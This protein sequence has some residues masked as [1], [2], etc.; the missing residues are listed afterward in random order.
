MTAERGRTGSLRDEP[1]NWL[2]NTSCQ[3]PNRKHTNN[4]NGLKFYFYTD[5]CHNSKEKEPF[6]YKVGRIK[7]GLEGETWEEMEE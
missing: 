3:A 6:N 2:S 5:I 7:E 4:K 1:L